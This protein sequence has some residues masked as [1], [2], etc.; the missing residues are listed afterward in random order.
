[1][2]IYLFS[3]YNFPDTQAYSFK[4]KEMQKNVIFLL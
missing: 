4:P 1:M 3:K 2:F